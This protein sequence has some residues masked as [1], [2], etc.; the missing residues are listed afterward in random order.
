M[1]PLDQESPLPCLANTIETALTQASIQGQISQHGKGAGAP[2][3][4]D[5]AEAQ[6]QSFLPAARIP[7]DQPPLRSQSRHEKSE[8]K[9]IFKWDTVAQAC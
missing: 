4:S 9:R 6:L 8:V 1:C 2:P 7:C 3:L 5:C